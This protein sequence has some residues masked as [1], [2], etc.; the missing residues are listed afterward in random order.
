MTHAGVKQRVAIGAL[1]KKPVQILLF[2][3]FAFGLFSTFS[4]DDAHASHS[5]VECLICHLPLSSDD[6]DAVLDQI[7]IDVSWVTGILTFGKD[8]ATELVTRHSVVA[9]GPPSTL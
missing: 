5:E 2:V 6:D 3:V 9:R 4:H 1:A 7:A 8:T